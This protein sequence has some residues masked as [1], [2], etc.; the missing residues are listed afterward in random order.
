M[1]IKA[2]EDIIAPQYSMDLPGYE[3][4]QFLINMDMIYI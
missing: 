4:V 3:K 2:A 1:Y